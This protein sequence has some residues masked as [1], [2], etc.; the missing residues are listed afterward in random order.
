MLLAGVD[1]KV[2]QDQLGHA[3]LAMTTDTYAHV[4]QRQRDASA[5]AI[6]RLYGA[7]QASR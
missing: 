7:D 4:F 6:K 5:A 1:A 2:V 3:T